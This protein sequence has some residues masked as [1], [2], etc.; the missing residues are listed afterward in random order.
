[1][2]FCRNCS[3]GIRDK[4]K[5]CHICGAPQETATAVSEADVADISTED[6]LKEKSYGEG[7]I[8]QNKEDSAKKITI[9]S[10]RHQ[11]EPLKEA[12]SK[13]I[14]DSEVQAS[15]K[16]KKEEADVSSGKDGLKTNESNELNDSG[17]KKDRSHREN[18][19]LSSSDKCERL[20]FENSN[21]DSKK[22]PKGN[23]PLL[24][25]MILLA[26]L[27]CVGA[28]AAFLVFKNGEKNG[29]SLH[30]G[31]DDNVYS[32]AE[33]GLLGAVKGNNLGEA[34]RFIADGANINA[35]DSD[36][37]TPLHI[38]ASKGSLDIVRLLVDSGAIIGDLN[39]RQATP[40]HL[41][42]SADSVEVIS[43]LLG[44]GADIEAVDSS[45]MTPLNEAAKQGKEKSVNILTQSG[46]NIN[47][48][49]S[50][51]NTPL[52]WAANYGY[53]AIINTLVSAGAFINPVNRDDET[54]LDRAMA[55][56]RDEAAR[57]IKAFGGKN[58]KQ[59]R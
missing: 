11:Q 44:K 17:A 49:D 43:F 38:A 29:E 4:A 6:S 5:Y 9:Q 30:I 28:V 25:I 57:I 41:A 23:K 51:L 56:G 42:A 34:S 20:D 39:N 47:T 52:H 10:L 24:W 16:C 3:T 12:E 21:T 2:G 13:E 27:I 35:K 26:V 46:A 45:V 40:L 58:Y 59:L 15:D 36:G 22:S 1:M 37:N 53:N 31:V 50:R 8:A 7:E 33:E 18:E 54:P 48:S 14:S 32:E 19:R 55:Q